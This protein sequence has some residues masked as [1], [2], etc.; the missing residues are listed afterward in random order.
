MIA[1]H[2]GHTV[3]ST[4]ISIASAVARIDVYERADHSCSAALLV[5][6]APPGRRLAWRD[7]HRVPCACLEA[8]EEMARRMVDRAE[9]GLCVGC[10]CAIVPDG[11]ACA[12]CAEGR[13]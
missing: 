13:G 8:A 7:G 9:H 11:F 5:R 4:P 10:G 3:S 1:D 2:L 12:A 6:S